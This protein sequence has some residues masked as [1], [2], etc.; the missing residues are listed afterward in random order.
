MPP[1]MNKTEFQKSSKSIHNVYSETADLSMKQAS[2]EVKETVFKDDF[3]EETVQ[4]LMEHG[5][6]G[7]MHHSTVL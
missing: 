4:V 1:P 5:R 3:V 6:K 7:G 2:C